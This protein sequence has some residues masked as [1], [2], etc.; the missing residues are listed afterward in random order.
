MIGYKLF[1]K[2]RDGTY[3]PLFINARQKLNLG[4]L[5]KA[6]SHKRKGFAFRPGWHIC[7]KP[8]AP[9]LSERNRV[10]C[11]VQFTHRETLFRPKA[12]GGIW[13]L[14]SDIKILNE[15]RRKGKKL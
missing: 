7:C 6:E 2:R 1:R 9:H 11:K 14:G 12:Q 3:G 5:Y 15:V 8:H 4:V 13:Y 10:W